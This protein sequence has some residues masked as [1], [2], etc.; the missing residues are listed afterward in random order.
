M[1]PEEVLRRFQGLAVVVHIAPE[2]YHW[3]NLAA[4]P[5]CGGKL[6]LVRLQNVISDTGHR[7]FGLYW[8]GR[9]FR[10]GGGWPQRSGR[11]A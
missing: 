6:D 5:S 2:L 1:P 10:A 11:F 3:S 4:G 9:Q 8:L 7:L